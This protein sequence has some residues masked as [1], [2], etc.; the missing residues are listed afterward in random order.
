MEVSFIKRKPG[1]FF[2]LGI[3]FCWS[4]QARECVLSLRSP[5]DS[6][7]LHKQCLQ[8]SLIDWVSLPVAKCAITA[9]S[10]D[11]VIHPQWKS[12]LSVSVLKL[13]FPIII[14]AC[15]NICPQWKLASAIFSS[16]VQLYIGQ[17]SHLHFHCYTSSLKHSCCLCRILAI[18]FVWPLPFHR[19]CT[20][21]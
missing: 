21:F 16:P 10:H 4:R 17:E 11:N 13:A 20:V 12:G 5:G 18:S 6:G 3:Y 9:E 19:Q 1:Q 15:P 8:C 14:V 2:S 7:Q